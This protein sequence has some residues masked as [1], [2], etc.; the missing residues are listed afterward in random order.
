MAIPKRH[1]SLP[2]TY[3]VTSK[4]WQSHSLFHTTRACEV[5]VDSLIHY[6]ERRDYKL[7]SF[8]LM[9]DHFHLLL[10]PSDEITVERAIQFVKGGSAKL[11]GD[12]MHLQ[13]PVWQR[14]FTD[15]RIRDAADY[16]QHVRYVEL[17]PVKRKLADAPEQYPWSSASGKY[18]MDHAPQR[19][20]PHPERDVL[21]HG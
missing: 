15:H 16:A 19:L 20:K 17:N 1:Q 9:P 6:R 3:F 8:V 7:H 11:L 5:F 2:G 12:E 21:R 4:T 18:Q 13:F 14:G 10:T